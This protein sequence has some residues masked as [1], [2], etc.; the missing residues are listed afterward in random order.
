MEIVVAGF[1]SVAAGLL[2]AYASLS[3]FMKLIKRG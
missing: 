2:L 3:G 1:F